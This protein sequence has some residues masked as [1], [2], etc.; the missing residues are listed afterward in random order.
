MRKSRIPAAVVEYA[1]HAL[2]LGGEVDQFI[3]LGDGDRERL[4]DD[5]VLARFDRLLCDREVA[6]V[7][8]SHDNDVRA[9]H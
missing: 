5:D 4:V 6:G 9:V 3:C 1:E 8:R 2:S 7:R